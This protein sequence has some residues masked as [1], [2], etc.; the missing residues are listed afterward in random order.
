MEV[1]FDIEDYFDTAEIDEMVRYEA[2]Y[3]IEDKVNKALRDVS[4]SDII[5]STASKIA[6]E[7]LEN[8]EVKVY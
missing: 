3:V 1:S 8:Y 6:I 7:I 5:Y 2:K 4:V